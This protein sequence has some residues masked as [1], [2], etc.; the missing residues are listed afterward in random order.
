MVAF[1]LPLQCFFIKQGTVLCNGL[2]MQYWARCYKT[3]W[4]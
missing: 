4:R 1:C 3:C 2:V